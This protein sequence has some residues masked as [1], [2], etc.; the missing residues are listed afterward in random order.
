MQQLLS[1]GQVEKWLDYGKSQTTYTTKS[2]SLPSPQCVG[3]NLPFAFMFYFYQQGYI[4]VS[5]I[6]EI[7]RF[8]HL[9]GITAMHYSEVGCGNNNYYSC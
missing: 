7:K 3:S 5:F 4:N 8:Y 9:I 6:I 2:E 1:S